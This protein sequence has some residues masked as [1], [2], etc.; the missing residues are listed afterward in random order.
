MSLDTI[1][2]GCAMSGVSLLGASFFTYRSAMNFYDFL[3]ESLLRLQGHQNLLA[4]SKQIGIDRASL[5]RFLT[6]ER[7]LT[8]ESIQ[9]IIDKLGYQVFAPDEDPYPGNKQGPSRDV[10]FVDAKIVSAADGVRPPQA[11]N[12]IAVP[13]VGQ[14]GAGPGIV[15][16]DKV[17]SWVLVYANH[18]SVMR[19]SNLLAV[20][21]GKESDSMEPLISPY[22]IVLVD[23]DDF[24]PQQDGRGI[25]L[26]R[27]PGQLGGGMIKRVQVHRVKGETQVVFYSDNKKYGP[28][29]PRF[30]DADYGDRWE[31]AIVGRCV[32]S[33]SDLTRK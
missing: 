31:N 17:E 6:G 30:L 1:S 15:P 25:Y 8:G 23:R 16:E 3:R 7:G 27:E 10:C 19:R 2:Q 21:V 26:V 33:W 18:H 4:F 32:W 22:D 29:P 28:E 13:L 5:A 20:E 9:K 24:V 12:Y 14:A 11:E